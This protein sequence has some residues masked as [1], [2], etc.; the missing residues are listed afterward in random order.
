ML[1]L[2]ELSLSS[3]RLVLAPTLDATPDVSV[4]IQPQPAMDPDRQRFFV[5]VECADFDAFEAALADDYTVQDPLVLTDAE[6]VRIYRLTLTDDVTVIS[7][8]VAELGGMVLEMR[9]HE[10]GWHVKL[11]VPDR[12][13]LASFRDFC[14]RN[15]IEYT[16]ERLYQTEPGRESDVALRASQRETLV[17]AFEAGYFEVP[18]AVSQA[19][20][21]AELDISDSAVSQRVRRAVERLIA[22]T[23]ADESRPRVSP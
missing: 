2:S 17:T 5:Q 7:P 14:R 15:D 6:D 8:R 9:S 20:L 12:E 1:A 3:P 10:R 18:R 22:D 23:I 4:S 21:A 13:T 11:Q 16:L 19:E